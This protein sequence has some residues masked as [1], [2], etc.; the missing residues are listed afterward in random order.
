MGGRRAKRKRTPPITEPKKFRNG[1][2]PPPPN[3]QTNKN[4]RQCLANISPF[5]DEK[6]LSGHGLVIEYSNQKVQYE[7][8]FDERT[9][10]GGEVSNSEICGGRHKIR[11]SGCVHTQRWR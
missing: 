11:T 6:S 4:G 2:L 10:H 9:R 5:R 8:R 1:S 3:E 7:N